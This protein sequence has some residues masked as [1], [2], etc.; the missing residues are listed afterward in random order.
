MISKYRKSKSWLSQTLAEAASICIS[1]F[2]SS[3]LEELYEYLMMRYVLTDEQVD[4][5]MA[6]PTNNSK[7]GENK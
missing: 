5:I 1:N 6:T 7:D 3:R 2:L 4:A